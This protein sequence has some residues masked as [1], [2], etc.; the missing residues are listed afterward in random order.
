MPR[1]FDPNFKYKKPSKRLLT[2][3][4]A[5]VASAAQ[6]DQWYTNVEEEIREFLRDDQSSYVYMF[7]T[8]RELSVNAF[9]TYSDA[10]TG[11]IAW[12]PPGAAWPARPI[13]PA[14]MFQVHYDEFMADI[15]AQDLLLWGGGAGA[16]G[17]A[18][19]AWDESFCVNYKFSGPTPAE[20]N[21]IIMGAL[22]GYAHSGFTGLGDLTQTVSFTFNDMPTDRDHSIVLGELN[23]AF[24]AGITPMKLGRAHANTIAHYLK[25]Q[26]IMTDWGRRHNVPIALNHLS[27]ACWDYI[28]D[29]T[30]L[31][32]NYR[33]AMRQVS[34]V[35]LRDQNTAEFED[36][37]APIV[38]GSEARERLATRA[39]ANLLA[40]LEA[41]DR[42]HQANL[43]SINS[44]REHA[45][46]RAQ[47]RNRNR[48][49]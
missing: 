17:A 9:K 30:L 49:D 25:D 3:R 35:A 44:V 11:A 41:R 19:A 33:A 26:D 28:T 21:E 15:D 32:D 40:T 29:P 34:V 4:S 31:N 22:I 7:E 48:D 14:D 23:A 45:R 8:F 5:A 16:P 12:A 1:G 46:S 27:F 18:P 10:A 42:I 37:E 20:F 36:P 39:S 43:D 24:P 38:P 2:V 47:T 6:V 13:K